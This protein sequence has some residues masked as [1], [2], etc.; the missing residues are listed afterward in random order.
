MKYRDYNF[1][2]KYDMEECNA[3]KMS[4]G[5]RAVLYLASQVL[6]ISEGEVNSI[7]ID[8]PE[9]HL[10]PSIM[11][12]LWAE[13]EKARKD[14]LFIYIT[15]DI[16]F[17]SIHRNSDKIWVNKYIRKEKWDYQV[18]SKNDELPEQLLLEI[19]G[20]RQNILFVES[21]RD[22]YDYKLY[23]VLFPNMHVMPSG[24]CEQVS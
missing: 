6:S 17:A 13:L 7:I 14:I 11:H 21:D 10:H 9:I 24:G 16:N 5:E 2:A 4:D 8:E 19:L 1:W 23:T 18:L 15:H 20:C 22:H 3:C 12:N